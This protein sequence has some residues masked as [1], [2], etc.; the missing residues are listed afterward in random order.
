[1]SILGGRRVELLFW[2]L[3]FESEV[4]EREEVLERDLESLGDGAPL[5]RIV[6]SP[7]SAPEPPL[8]DPDDFQEACSKK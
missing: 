6:R 4:L 1:M 2:L 3:R 5:A 7:V 8:V